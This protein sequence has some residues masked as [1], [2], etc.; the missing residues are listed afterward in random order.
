MVTSIPW[1]QSA[2]NFFLNWMFL[3]VKAEI[4]CAGKG[5]VW[6]SSWFLPLRAI[7]LSVS[8]RISVT[9]ET[10]IVSVSWK[11]LPSLHGS[12]PSPPKKSFILSVTPKTSKTEIRKPIINYEIFSSVIPTLHATVQSPL[13][14]VIRHC[15][16]TGNWDPVSRKSLSQKFPSDKNVTLSGNIYKVL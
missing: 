5:F 3:N 11:W 16:Q 13:R 15:I 7:P 1:L 9:I 6:R 12:S 14:L 2:F 4:L 8:S 10:I